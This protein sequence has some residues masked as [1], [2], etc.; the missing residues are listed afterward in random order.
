MGKGRFLA[1]KR[2]Q[3]RVCIVC[4][5][6][7]AI[8]PF[9]VTSP[10]IQFWLTAALFRSFM[11]SHSHKIVKI[12]Q[13]GRKEEPKNCLQGEEQ[14]KKIDLGRDSESKR[15]HALHF[16]GGPFQGEYIKRR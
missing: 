8:L 6:S 10:D 1:T 12:Q 16:G 3:K 9:L 14:W 15:K 11:D 4:L 13:K 7:A 5:A 2:A